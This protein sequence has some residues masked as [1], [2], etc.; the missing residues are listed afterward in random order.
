LPPAI[1]GHRLDL[2]LAGLCAL[3]ALFAYRRAL[4]AYFALDDFQV[5]EQARGLVPH[6]ASLWRYLSGHAYFGLA[7]R[8]FAANPVP[9]HVVNW[10]LHATNSVLIYAFARSRGARPVSSAFAAALFAAS[11]LHFGAVFPATGVGEL[12]A[13]GLTL[14]AFL[15]AARGGLM[16]GLLAAALFGAA[17]LCKENVLLLP[18]LL[19]LPAGESAPRGIPSA[20]GG[21]RLPRP[22]NLRERF[23]RAAPLFAASAAMLA[24]LAFSHVR[25]RSLGGSAYEMQFGSNLFHNLMTYITWS[26]NLA[27]ATPEGAGISE[28]AWKLGLAG[29]ALIALGAWAGRKGAGLGLLGALWWLLALLPVLPLIHHSYLYYLY[30]PLA[31]L[32]IWA[33]GLLELPVVPRA[34]IAAVAVA[35][36]A[37]LLAGA[38]AARSNQLLSARLDEQLE[39]APIPRDP[40]LRKSEMARNAAGDMRAYV[41][42]GGRR[43]MFLTPA[44]SQKIYDA[45]SGQM[46]DPA[47][48]HRHLYN[49]FEECLDHGRALRALYPQLDTVAFVDRWTPAYSN[50]DI[51]IY[52]GDGHVMNLGRGLEGHHSL[53]NGMLSYQY[54]EAARQHLE[55]VVPLYPDDPKLR[56][57]YSYTLG[58]LGDPAGSRE[59]LVELVRRAPQDSLALRARALLAG[60]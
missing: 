55:T 3:L 12:L 43:G 59:Q 53:V 17:L 11:R 19:L 32:A 13:L 41:T 33:A 42:S 25:S 27:S 31:G 23:L 46:L 10:A 14:G 36:A 15:V 40:Y 1:S 21:D 18:L 16:R 29:A 28:S 49:L 48:S 20:A 37:A 56:W 51:L 4:G 50:F 34:G 54:F 45:A 5:M 7:T 35:A 30:T 8:L 39:G 52:S 24:Y 6:A 60:S 47:A 22:E 44:G 57:W 26:F 38:Y 2:A 58:K 9:Y